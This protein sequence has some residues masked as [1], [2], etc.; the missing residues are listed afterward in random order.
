MKWLKIALPLL[1][2]A[3]LLCG[4]ADKSTEQTPATPPEQTETQ[5]GGEPAATLPPELDGILQEAG[6][7]TTQLMGTQVIT[8]KAAGNTARICFYEKTDDGWQEALPA[9]DGYVGQNGVTNEKAEGDGCTP[10]GQYTLG[11]AFGICEKP[12]TTLEYRQ[13]TADSY[14]VDDAASASYNTWVEDTGDRD[15]ESAEHLIDYPG[16]YDYAMVIG[17]NTENIVPGAGSAIFLHCGYSPTRGCVAMD[18]EAM[19]AVLKWLNSE[20]QPSIVI[21]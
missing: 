19:L 3:A 6:L 20:S 5:S 10:A 14:W 4:C 13:V 12:E 21:I 7:E 17:Y 16:K 9:T 15:W 11:A 2:M 8:V 18:T 1:I